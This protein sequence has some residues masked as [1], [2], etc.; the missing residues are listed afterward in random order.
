MQQALRLLADG[1]YVEAGR[2]F[3]ELADHARDNGRPLRS[4]QLSLQAAR[5]WLESGDGN[6]AALRAQHA[7]QQFIAGGRPG[8]A[9][10]MVHNIANA[11]RSRGFEPQAAALE[12]DTQA[13][14]AAVGLSLDSV[15]ME[16][17]PP[18][19]GTLP[20]TCSQCGGPLRADE[21]EWIN[22][23]SAECPYCGSTVTT[24]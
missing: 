13:R 23:T 4:A 18:Q 11:L 10:R 2:L 22:A 8:R 6:A 24:H 9:A 14:L 12:Q 16:P 15:R 20:P 5:A 19:Q 3:G 21:V 17:A 1:R 7:A